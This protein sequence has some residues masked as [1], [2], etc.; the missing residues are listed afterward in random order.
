MK[1]IVFYILV[2]FSFTGKSQTTLFTETFEACG[3]PLVLSGISQCGWR[4]GTFA[5]D[6]ANNRWEI[7]TSAC[8]ITGSRS[9][10]ITN[11]GTA[12]QYRA[13]RRCAKVAYYATPINATGYYC[14]TMTFNWK[15]NGE[16]D[17]G[18]LF[19][20]LMPYYSLDGATC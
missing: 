5:G 16:I 15:S 6:N 10:Q 13:N 4:M 7:R 9:L 8:Q 2:L 17:A 19:D 14:N 12:C 11:N 1:K 18:T 20:Y 3:N